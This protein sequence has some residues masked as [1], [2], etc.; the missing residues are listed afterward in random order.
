MIPSGFLRLVTTV[1]I[2]QTICVM[3]TPS[4]ETNSQLLS[5]ARARVSFLVWALER[6]RSMEN[7]R[8]VIWSRIEEAYL[9]KLEQAKN[10]LASLEAQD[11]A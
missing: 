6:H 8:D 7:T 5:E 4:E 3:L 2:K 9:V 10:K 11:G 1:H